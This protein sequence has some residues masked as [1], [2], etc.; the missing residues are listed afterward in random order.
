MARTWEDYKQKVRSKGWDS[1]VALA[2]DESIGQMIAAVVAQRMKLGWSQRDLAARARLTQSAVARF[3]SGASTPRVDTLVRLLEALGLYLRAVSCD[4]PEE[5]PTVVM[6][7]TMTI[8]Q[9][10]QSKAA[11]D[12]KK[13]L[14]TQLELKEEEVVFHE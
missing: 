12:R 1:Q 8:A 5:A 13:L 3:E 7:D 9:L 10:Q 11:L 4:F 14:Y 6:M 2:V